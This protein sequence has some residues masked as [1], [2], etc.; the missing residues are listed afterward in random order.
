[1]FTNYSSLYNILKQSDIVTTTLIQ[2]LNLRL[3]LASE[4]LSWFYLDVRYKPSKANIILDTLLRLSIRTKEARSNDRLD[5]L[6]AL[7]EAYYYTVTL[8]KIDP[9]F[10]KSIVDSYSTNSRLSTIVN[11]VTENTKLRDNVVSLPFNYTKDR[12]LF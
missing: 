4:Y 5:E 8:V 12:L 3:V 2:K 11:I 1:M 10:K 7:L 6:D 9:A